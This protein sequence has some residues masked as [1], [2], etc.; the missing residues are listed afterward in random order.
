MSLNFMYCLFRAF[1]GVNG[2]FLQMLTDLF[3][4]PNLY[5]VN[6]NTWPKILSII[7]AEIYV[8]FLE[9]NS[10]MNTSTAPLIL[11]I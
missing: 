4:F 6:N 7:F 5:L 2:F 11:S 9:N 3:Y 8:Q 10:S 1:Y